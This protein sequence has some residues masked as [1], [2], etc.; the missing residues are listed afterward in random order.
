MRGVKLSE[1]T[2]EEA[3]EAL[4]Q[5]SIVMLPIGGGTK[6][7]GP[8]LPGGTDYYV[9]D[10]L[11]QRVV[12]QA[13]V[14]MLPTLPYAYYPAFIDWEGSVS[15]EAVHFINLVSDII[16]S[17][18]RHGITKFLILDG[19]VSTHCPMKILSS[20]LHNQLG[21]EVA[22]TDI[23]GLGKEVEAQVCEQEFGGHADESETSTMLAIKPE[24]VKMERA[25]KEHRGAKPGTISEQGIRK[26]AIGGKMLTKN[27]INGDPT[28]ATPEKGDA[29]IQ[30][31]VK[32]IVN[33]INNF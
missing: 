22:V 27:G 14:I 32:D 20:D 5:Y 19:G 30:A 7:H 16:K 4:Q 15:I 25:V 18:V 31:K 10:E 2:W 24:L 23:L 3:K 8:H 17:L 12:E 21:I 1:I 9:V 33:F 29:I 13:P 11:A 28:L 26:I 6:E